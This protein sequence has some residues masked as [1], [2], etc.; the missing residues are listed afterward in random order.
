MQA[1]G[2][3]DRLTISTLLGGW[4]L[5]AFTDVFVPNV[6]L[7]YRFLDVGRWSLAVG[8]GA[9]WVRVRNV[10]VIG[11]TRQTGDVV[12]FPFQLFVTHR[13]HFRLLS[14]LEATFVTGST[15][16]ED[17]VVID[18]FNGAVV[19]S[20]LEFA[21]NLEYPVARHVALTLTGR[22]VAWVP[23]GKINVAYAIDEFNQIRVRGT[24][25]AAD[26]AGSYNVL[27]GIAFYSRIFDFRIG[28]GYGRFIIP[29]LGFVYLETGPVISFAAYFRF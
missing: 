9:T 1:Y 14:T 11:S 29:E 24:I 15:T 2:I 8:V 23:H 5:P 7:R 26:V 20:G 21:L 17:G 22:V 18:D 19:S 3:V 6:M 13:A 12:A 25:T 27:G 28:A 4:I 10:K 16:L